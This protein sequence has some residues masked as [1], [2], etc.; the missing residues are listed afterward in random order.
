MK[1]YFNTTLKVN[2]FIL[3]RKLYN[4][5]NSNSLLYIINET[6]FFNFSENSLWI[7]DILYFKN[8]DNKKELSYKIVFSNPN[9]LI[10]I[11]PILRQQYHSRTI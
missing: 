10:D 11:I 4:E 9:N 6:E 1:I 2:Y 8:L 5:C 7:I 3:Y